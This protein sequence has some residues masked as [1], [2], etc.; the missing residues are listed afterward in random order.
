MI[1]ADKYML[2]LIVW[3]VVVMFVYGLDKLFA[4]IQHRRISEKTLI[5][6]AFL[7]GG[8]GGIMGMVLFNHKTS[9]MK[10]RILVPLACVVL[11]VIVFGFIKCQGVVDLL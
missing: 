1:S 2:I 11:I 9:K 7:L 10:F 5:L 4:K 8:F 6:S 3:N